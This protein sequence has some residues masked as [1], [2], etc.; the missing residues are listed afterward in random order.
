MFIAKGI[1]F[2]D[3]LKGCW[4][5]SF[6]SSRAGWQLNDVIICIC[7]ALVGVV[8]AFVLEIIGLRRGDKDIATGYVKVKVTFTEKALIEYISW[9]QED[10]KTLRGIGK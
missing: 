9:Q 6:F 2:I 1:N 3:A 4:F 10:K 8:C 7:I 5:F